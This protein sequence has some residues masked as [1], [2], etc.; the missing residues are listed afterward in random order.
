MLCCLLFIGFKFFHNTKKQTNIR[1]PF[2]KP[3]RSVINDEDL[4]FADIDDFLD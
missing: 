3:R 2:E 1:S 4:K